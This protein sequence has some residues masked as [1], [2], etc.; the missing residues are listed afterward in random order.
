LAAPETPLMTLQDRAM[1]AVLV[2]LGV[3]LLGVAVSR[4]CG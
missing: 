3:F 4:G 1:M 2:V